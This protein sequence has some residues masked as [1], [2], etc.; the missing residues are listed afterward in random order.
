MSF[1]SVGDIDVG[2]LATEFGGGGHANAS[3]A[4]VKDSLPFFLD[5]LR[6]RLA[7]LL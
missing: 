6:S 7:H 5:R 1:R 4:F 2:I 3:G